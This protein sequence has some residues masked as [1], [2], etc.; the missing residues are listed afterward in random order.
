MSSTAAE[1]HPGIEQ[2]RRI[3]QFLI[4]EAAHLD[5]GR[6]DDWLTL[7][8]EDFLYRVPVPLSREDPALGRYDETLEFANE[9]K[10]FLAMRFGRVASD[11]AWAERPTA[12]I[13]HFVTN[14]RIQA[15][16]PTPGSDN[17]RWTVH[18]NVLV[19]R[20]RLPEPPVLASAERRDVIELIQGSLRL[21]RRDVFLDAEVPTDGQLAVIF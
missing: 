15:A 12:S 3:E 9:S 10:S 20:A 16:E 17:P 21:V 14:F 18:T 2:N 11:H 13:R 5:A 4:E 6:Y 1:R 8:D 7:L 19:V